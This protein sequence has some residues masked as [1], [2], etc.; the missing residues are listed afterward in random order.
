MDLETLAQSMDWMT[1]G[2]RLITAVFV[3]QMQATFTAGGVALTPLIVLRTEDVIV[4]HLMVRRIEHGLAESG[5]AELETKEQRATRA[6][7][8][9]AAGKARERLRKAMKDL[10]DACTKAGTPIDTGLADR[11]RPL[12]QQAEGTIEDALRFAREKRQ[13]EEAAPCAQRDE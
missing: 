11:L 10:E 1:A 3:E 13:R 9:E 2:E 7:I 6:A 5:A 8:I 12:L 4:S